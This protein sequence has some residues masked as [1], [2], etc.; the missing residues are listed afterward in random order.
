MIDLQDILKDFEKKVNDEEYI[1]KETES[2]LKYREEQR[3][4]EE[5]FFKNGVLPTK[6]KIPKKDYIMPFV[7]SGIYSKY[8]K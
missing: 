3:E 1:Q 5:Y 7:Y 4:F 8:H 6:N 2:Y